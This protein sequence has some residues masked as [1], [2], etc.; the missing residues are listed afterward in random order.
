MMPYNPLKIADL[1]N[2]PMNATQIFKKFAELS[3]FF[4]VLF[5]V[6]KEP[7]S[8]HKGHKENDPFLAKDGLSGLDKSPPFR[9]DRIRNPT[10]GWKRRN[11]VTFS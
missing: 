2:Q 8:K 6:K 1:A 7:Q 4:F 3:F 9:H 5:V 11:T 10:T